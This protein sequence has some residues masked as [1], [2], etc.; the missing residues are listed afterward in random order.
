MSIDNLILM[1]KAKDDEET[2][3]CRKGSHHHINYTYIKSP[4][5]FYVLYIYI[6]LLKQLV[7]ELE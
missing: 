5:T 1:A 4:G 6:S 7:G 3:R 2:D